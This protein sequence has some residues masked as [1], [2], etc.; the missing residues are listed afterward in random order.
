MCVANAK[1]WFDRFCGG[2]ENDK[3]N[4]SSFLLKKKFSHAFLI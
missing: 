2:R 4:N 1:L 3:H